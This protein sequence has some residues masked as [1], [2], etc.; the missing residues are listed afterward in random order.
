LAQGVQEVLLLLEQ[1]VA[2]LY[3]AQ[4]LLMAVVQ[5][6]TVAIVGWVVLPEVL[7]VE[8]QQEEQGLLET[9]H[10]LRQVK[11][12][13]EEMAGLIMVAAVEAAEQAQ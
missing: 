7:V 12:V 8:L 3:S 11:E 5:V 2:I 10:Q 4:S 13:A 6:C 9:R 1:M